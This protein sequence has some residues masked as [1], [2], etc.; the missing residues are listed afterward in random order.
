MTPGSGLTRRLAAVALGA[1]AL[2][3]LAERAHTFLSAPPT[4]LDDAY[5]FVRYADRLRHEGTLAWNPGGPAVWGATSLAHVL[6]VA[7]LRALAPDLPDGRVLT[8]A[9]ALAALALLPALAALCTRAA[10]ISGRASLDGPLW[11]SA[12]LLS[13]GYSDALTFHA[14]SGMD[15]LLAALALSGAL[16]AVLGLFARPGPARAGAVALLGVAALAVRPDLPPLVLGPAALG[17]VAPR[18]TASRLPPDTRR[19]LVTLAAATALFS[20]IAFACANTYFGTP[21]PLATWVK[22]HGHD[23]AFG[24]EWFWNPCR[25]LLVVGR[26]A[27]APLAVLALLA[28]RRDLAAVLPL[29]LPVALVWATL[30]CFNQVMGHLGRFY[31]P[32]LPLVFLAAAVVVSR[33]RSDPQ[34]LAPRRLAGGAVTLAAAGLS[35]G[36]AAD[37]YDARRPPDPPHPR[38]ALVSSPLPEVDDWRAMT[39]LAQALSSSPAGTTVALTEHGVIGARAPQVTLLDLSGLHDVAIAR[40]GI[41]AAT[42]LARAPDLIYLP[43]PDYHGLLSSLLE[44]T[45]LRRDYD[46]YP[47]AFAFGLALRRDSPRAAALRARL[48]PAFQA[49]YGTALS[50]HAAR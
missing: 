43:H 36:L 15:T 11:G 22:Q 33:R 27:L 49:L 26:A 23:A 17:L 25:F 47:E 6:V 1:L 12:I 5:V 8:I 35:L 18:L 46:L 3:L 4:E 30:T 44:S 40:R 16:F 45:A 7:A 9:S 50:I 31:A 24:G 42:L 20:A 38:E 39:A 32:A 37:R 2:A 13:L 48:E 29:V 34:P 10:P 28:R 41:D 21:L 14:T 19:A